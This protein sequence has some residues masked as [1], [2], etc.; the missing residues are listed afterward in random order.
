MNKL[1]LSPLNKTWLLD[2]DCT[3]VKHNGYKDG[4][5]VLLAGAKEFVEQIGS[6]D[7]IIILTS[8]GGEFRQTTVDFLNENNIRFNEIIFDMPMGERILIN[9]RKPSGL[10]MAYAVN[11]NR[12]E[13][14]DVRFDIDGGNADVPSA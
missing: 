10:D 6:D 8:R 14:L 1:T 5:D 2:L 7:K 13:P 12:D 3:L 11:K 9:D 4:G